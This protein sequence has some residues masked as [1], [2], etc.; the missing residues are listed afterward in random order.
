MPAEKIVITFRTRLNPGYDAELTALGTRMY[1]LAAS[2]PGFLLYQDFAASD[3]EFLTLV[4]FD[5]AEH[6][7]AWRMHP[8]H[9]AAQ[10]LGREKYFSWYKIQVCQLLREYEVPPPDPA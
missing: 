1:E 10:K 6:L 5:T 3:G 4:E 7:A 2:M 8:E 9:V